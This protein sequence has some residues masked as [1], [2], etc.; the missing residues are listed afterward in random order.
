[1]GL[2]WEG[3][4]RYRFKRMDKMTFSKDE[5]KFAPKFKE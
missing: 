5:C 4:V 2:K 1:M 3:C